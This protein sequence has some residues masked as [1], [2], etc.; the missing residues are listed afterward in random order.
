MRKKVL[1]VIVVNLYLFLAVNFSVD[2]NEYFDTLKYAYM[3]LEEDAVYGRNF[4]SRNISY[5][6]DGYFEIEDDVVF[7]LNEYIQ[8]PRQSSILTHKT[9]NNISDELI[10]SI[11]SDFDNYFVNATRLRSAS[12]RYNCHS[13]AW[14][15]TSNSNVYWMNDPSTYYQDHS[16]DEVES[17]IVG[18]IICYFNSDD[19]NIHSGIVTSLLS[20]TANNV[21]GSSNL[22][23][24][25]SKWGAAGLYSHRGDQCPYTSYVNGDASYVK[26]YRLHTH[27]Y[28]YTYANPNYHY[29]TCSCGDTFTE[30]HEWELPS[31]FPLST[32]AA[33]I[34]YVCKKCGCSKL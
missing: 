8:T 17:P 5:E 23:M 4:N 22:V 33:P 25:T 18:D 2:A 11:N 3:N 15:S 1:L 24:V 28:L 16:Y 6:Y 21:C 9:L 7:F 27:S 31:M 30:L 13:Y 14:Y 29:A 10:S 32:Y 34:K 19:E 26:Y 20:G 12:A